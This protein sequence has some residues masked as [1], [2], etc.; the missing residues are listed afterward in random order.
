MLLTIE[1]MWLGVSE[2]KNG[3]FTSSYSCINNSN[4]VFHSTPIIL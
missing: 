1:K 2:Q 4:C 3:M